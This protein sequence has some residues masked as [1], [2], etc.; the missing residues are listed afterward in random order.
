MENIRSKAINKLRNIDLDKADIS[1]L[2]DRERY[3]F[4]QRLAGK[5]LRA[6]SEEMGLS[7]ARVSQIE[8]RACHRILIKNRK[9]IRK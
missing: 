1:H 5:T 7:S 2:T 3:I 4:K 6:I 9:L 8:K